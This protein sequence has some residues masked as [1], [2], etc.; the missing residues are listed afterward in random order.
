MIS[1]ICDQ[2]L[3]FQGSVFTISRGRGFMVLSSQVSGLDLE[4]LSVRDVLKVFVRSCLRNWQF[5]CW[6]GSRANRYV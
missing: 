6:D 3:R 1:E 5:N 2:G 4:V